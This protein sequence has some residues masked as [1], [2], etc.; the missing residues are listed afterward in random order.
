MSIEKVHDIFNMTS[1]EISQLS[2]E[3]LLNLHRR[4]HQLYGAA[5]A[6]G[7]ATEYRGFQQHVWVVEEM[8][9]R[10]MNHNPHDELDEQSEKLMKGASDWLEER[11]KIVDD[12]VL[13][14]AYVSL[15]GSAVKSEE[16]NDIDVLVR[17][18]EERLS[19]GQKESLYLLIRKLIDPDKQ[20]KKLHL[21]FNSQGPHLAKDQAY[22]PLYDL[23]LRP[24]KGLEFVSKTDAIRVD[25]GCGNNKPEGYLGIDKQ[26]YPEVDIVADLE[27]GIPLPDNYADEIRAWHVLE[28][29]SDKEAIMSEIW[30]V[31]KPG[32]KFVFEVPSTRG[33]G[34]FAHPGH[35]SFWN[36]SSFYFWTQDNLL[37]N[38]PRF[39]VEELEEIEHGDLV[40]VRGVL[41]KPEQIEKRELKPIARFPMQKPAMKLYHAQTEAFSPDEIWPWVKKHLPNGV[42]A[43]EKLN[44]F[45]SCLQKAGDR[46][47]IFFE[48]SQKERNKQLPEIT[49][50]L[51][52]IDADFILD[53]N[54]G[55]EQDGKPWPRIK[56]MTLTA[57]K[58]ELPEDAYP[59]V[60]V[61]DL[62][63]W[64]EKGGDVHEK[65]FA[66]RRKLLE[67]F[68]DKYLKGDKHFAITDQ[69]KI[70]S[71]AD[72]KRAWEKLGGMYLSEGIVLKDLAAPFEL[73]PGTDGMAKIKHA[74]EIKAW[75]LDVKRN[76]NGTYGFRGGLLLGDADFANI[77]E[78]ED[79]KVVD[80]GWSF[81]AP[82]K[83][84]TGDIVTFEVEEIIVRQ[85]DDGLHLDWLG[86]KPIDVDKSRSR[87]YFANQVV[88]IAR[89]GGVLQEVVEKQRGEEGEGDETR[90]EAA[91][92]NWE[93]NWHEAMPLSGKALPF[94]LHAHW[95]G[96]TEEETKLSMEELL[97]TDHSL[98]FDLRL[99]T[100]RFDGWW[101][102]SLFAGTTEENREE[103]RIFRMMHDPD[104][105][106]QSAPKLFGPSVWLKVGLDK[107][108]VVEPGGVGSTS[109][110]YSKFFAIDHGTWRLGFA[111]QHAVEIWLEG[112][113]LKGRFLW[114][115]V[116]ANGKKRIWIFTRPEDQR[117]YAKTHDFD[118]VVQEIR[119]KGQRYLVWPKDPDNLAKGHNLVDVTKLAKILKAEEER[120]YTLAV[121]YPANEKDAHDDYMT[122]EELE[123]TAWNYLLKHRRVGLMHKD[124]TEGAGEVVESYIYRGPVW[125]VNGE[126]VKPG[127]WLLGVV[128]SPE[129]WERIKK[130]EFTGF[131]IQGWGRKVK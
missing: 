116:P 28:H 39:E 119:D 92:R 90:G 41:R 77:V 9:R 47:S 121:A 49:E 73:K 83:A 79:Q 81:N 23:V 89:R 45:R 71:K 8:K 3:E 62:L 93:E 125:E 123:K 48:D 46:V 22:V 12:Q 99:G 19:K 11:L 82:F 103:L 37:E 2:D 63:Y 61:F 38:R 130:G 84:E 50:A 1:K 51:Q 66:E 105:K 7:E 21:L 4:L 68:Y 14:P 25:L 78:F 114:Q 110:K 43:E 10:G 57:D 111:R 32:G 126:K 94:V 127:D 100:D 76:K 120:R 53:A 131:S 117:P 29:L 72:L 88:D 80:L 15:V 104:E 87:P 54:V 16:P 64:D 20:G 13:V 31:L 17:E 35:R 24:R 109:R 122:P 86:A 96:L 115:Y 33:E 67:E 6:R 52:K 74:V 18:D 40:Y 55:V 59:K 113:K 97:E 58:P 36:K 106:I 124:G 75:V 108:L 30:R 101:G 102:I 118:E 27:Q 56:L 26:N 70:E 42:V 128:W 65:P 85:A 44:G 129:A 98:H 69:M 112:Q 107:P 34:A 60:T 95:R 5:K 91:H